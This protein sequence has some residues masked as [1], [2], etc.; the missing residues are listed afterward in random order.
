MRTETTMDFRLTP[1]LREALR[2]Y[3]KDHP[4]T[5][6]THVGQNALA[7]FLQKEGYIVTDAAGGFTAVSPLRD[8]LTRENLIRVPV[9]RNKRPDSHAA[10]TRKHSVKHSRNTHDQQA[11][12]RK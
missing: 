7:D 11:E 5:K 9:T 10:R 12:H 1:L 8:A 4:F 6:K 3:R 2:L